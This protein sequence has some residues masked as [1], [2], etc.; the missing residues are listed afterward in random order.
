M[1][2]TAGTLAIVIA[3]LGS[4]PG[5]APAQYELQAIGAAVGVAGG[6]GVT[7]GIVVARA[8][9]QRVY[10]DSAEDLISWQSA[11]MIIAPALGILFGTAGED[12]LIGSIAGSTI[13][14]AAGA[15]VGAGL[16]WLL[17]N[18]QEWPWAGGVIG[19][20]LGMSVGGILTGL[21][22]WSRDDDPNIPYPKELRFNISVPV[23]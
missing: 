4:M 10:L 8:R 18:Q 19:G 14:L 2:R 16:G 22:A 17:S 3:L 15:G 11:P 13:G 21:S 5:S 20:A 1:A 7:M 23:R 9:W 6:A 12:A